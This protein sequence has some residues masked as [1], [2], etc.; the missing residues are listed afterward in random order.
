MMVFAFE[1]ET[2]HGFNRRK[3]GISNPA[4]VVVVYYIVRSLE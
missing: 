2:R 3:G 4:R 1:A